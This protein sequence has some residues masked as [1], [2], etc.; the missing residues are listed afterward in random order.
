[1]RYLIIISLVLFFSCKDDNVIAP[2]PPPPEEVVDERIIDTFLWE[3]VIDPET[4]QNQRLYFIDHTLIHEDNVVFYVPGMG[5]FVSLNLQD[6]STYWDTRGTL[7]GAGIVQVPIKLGSDILYT[8]TSS[9]VS[10]NLDNGLRNFKEL[11]PNET[12]FQNIPIRIYKNKLYGNVKE[13]GTRPA[14]NEWIKVPLDKLAS[15][16]P[17]ER[18]GKYLASENNDIDRWSGNSLFYETKSGVDLMLFGASYVTY[19]GP[20]PFTVESRTISAFDINADTVAWERTLPPGP[21]G[22]VTSRKLDEERL[23]IPINRGL[24]CLDVE[25][26]M[27]LWSLDPATLDM[28]LSNGAGLHIYEDK[29]M[30]FG[31]LNTIKA[32]DKY[33]G[34]ELWR[35][36]LGI[37]DEDWHAQ[38]SNDKTVNFY[39]DR[40]YYLSSWGNLVSL[41]PDD[42]TIRHYFLEDRPTIAG[43]DV[44]LFEPDFDHS[45][46]VIS[47]EGIVYTSDGFRFLAFEVP[48]KDL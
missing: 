8:R 7:D 1:M 33:T 47:E 48:D 31:G 29:L 13:Y 11:W 2:P 21:V 32:F 4:I 44:E 39:N 14:F 40:I 23:Y 6:G 24:T 25:N 19:G 45:A 41:N 5:G 34:A 42:G 38:G 36:D 35:L 10:F 16:V 20:S 18:F 37:N 30:A 28:D 12:E 43:Y 17:W 27:V 3:K 22:G 9:M 26:N 46:M 15:P